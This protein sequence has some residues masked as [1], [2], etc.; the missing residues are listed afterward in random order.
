MRGNSA[1]TARHV[2]CA[3]PNKRISIT[4]FKVRPDSNLS[5]SPPTTPTSP[6]NG[7]MAL[8]Q[9]GITSP[10]PVANG[11][12]NGY[13]AM[14]VMPK[15]G[16][17]RSPVVMLSPMRPMVMSPRRMPHEGTGVF[18]PW[19]VGSR[20]PSKHLP[21]RAQKGRFLSL[22]HAVETAVADSTS[23]PGN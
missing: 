22:P 2:I 19:T 15:W 6:L 11:A 14:D 12:P 23:E 13:G 3:S 16:V 5:Q 21:P 8:W 7:A 1:D 4:F 20:R 17:L 10:Y 9:P 18:L